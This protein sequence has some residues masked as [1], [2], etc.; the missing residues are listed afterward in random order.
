MSATQNAVS[1]K[2][3]ISDSWTSVKGTFRTFRVWT[4]EGWSQSFIQ[5]L[6]DGEWTTLY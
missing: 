6:N 1:P 4:P 3:D 2:W 5:K